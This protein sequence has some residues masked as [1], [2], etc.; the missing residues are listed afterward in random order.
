M[1]VGVQSQIF[2]GVQSV[3]TY[4]LCAQAALF[5]SVEGMSH[6]VFHKEMSIVP[7]TIT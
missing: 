2:G 3:H 5:T 1:I 6:E 7:L 4:L